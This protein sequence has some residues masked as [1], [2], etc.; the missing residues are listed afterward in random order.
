MLVL[1][2]IIMIG[3]AFIWFIAE[4]KKQKDQFKKMNESFKSMMDYIFRQDTVII[5]TETTGL[6]KRS[7]VIEISIINLKGEV[8]FNSLIKP[9][10]RMSNDSKAV[11]IHGITNDQLKG[12]PTWADVHDQI[13]AI[14]EDKVVIS[15]NAAFDAR[16]IEQTARKHGL[17]SPILHLECAM[18]IYSFWH[19]EKSHKEGYKWHKLEDACHYL[20]IKIRGKSHQALT[21][22]FLT[23]NMLNNIKNKDILWRRKFL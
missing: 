19:G 6:T 10:V 7:E 21:D 1:F 16:L 20:G 17:K 4:Q 18:M 5:D 3:G 15:Y 13:C 23:L 22:C 2:I 9:M 14:L 11:K 8:L 12:K